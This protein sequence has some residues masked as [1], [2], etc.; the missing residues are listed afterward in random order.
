MMICPE[1]TLSKSVLTDELILVF[2]SEEKLCSKIFEMSGEGTFAIDLAFCHHPPHYSL[3]LHK[4][5]QK[6][7]CEQHSP[8]SLSYILIGKR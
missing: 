2:L 7:I 6:I 3:I 5:C 4:Q 1:E 8:L